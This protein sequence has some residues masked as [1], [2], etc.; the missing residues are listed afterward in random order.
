M[1]KIYNKIQIAALCA[2][3][4]LTTQAQ[5]LTLDN[6][7]RKAPAIM[8]SRDT[9]HLSFKSEF[10]AVQVL[11]NTNYSINNVPQLLTVYKE[12]KGNV[13]L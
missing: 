4:T 10:T 1:K 6:D 12:R 8:L 5:Q 11:T 9:V 3:T 7:T 13:I 2:L